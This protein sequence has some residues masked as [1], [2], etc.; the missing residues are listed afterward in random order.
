M[1]ASPVVTAAAA[2]VPSFF[3]VTVAPRTFAP[4]VSVTVPTTV[5]WLVCALRN[6]LPQRRGNREASSNNR[7]NRIPPKRPADAR[8]TVCDPLFAPASVDPVGMFNSEQQ[9][10]RP[11]PRTARMAL[12]ILQPL[13]PVCKADNCTIRDRC[14]DGRGGGYGKGR[15]PLARPTK[16]DGSPRSNPRVET[17]D[18]LEPG[19]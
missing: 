3:S 9:I 6:T 10:P 1:P 13:H 8:G 18:R 14:S 16:A 11:G 15:A 19:R 5:P 12:S 17:V 4:V 2:S 7:T